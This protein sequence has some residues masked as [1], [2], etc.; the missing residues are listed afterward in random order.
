MSKVVDVGIPLLS[1]GHTSDEIEIQSNP[2]PKKN[3]CISIGG[4]IV[5]GSLILVVLAGAGLIA[6]KQPFYV[7]FLEDP[8]DPA[9]DITPEYIIRGGISIVSNV[10]CNGPIFFVFDFVES[11]RR[12][13]DSW[14]MIGGY[15][16]AELTPSLDT[17]KLKKNNLYIEV[18]RPLKY[19]VL[20]RKGN[21]KPGEIT[22]EEFK[23]KCLQDIPTRSYDIEPLKPFASQILE[24]TSKKGDT[25]AELP[26]WRKG[27]AYFSLIYLLANIPGCMI[28]NGELTAESPPN[29][30]IPR[31]EDYRELVVDIFFG[32][33][34]GNFALT[35]IAAPGHIVEWLCLR[36]LVQ[37]FASHLPK[38]VEYT[39]NLVTGISGPLLFAIGYQMY[40]PKLPKGFQDLSDYKLCP[41][42]PCLEMS[43]AWHVV[44]FSQS[45]VTPFFFWVVVNQYF[46]HL[47]DMYNQIIIY[48]QEKSGLA[49]STRCGGW[50]AFILFVGYAG[51]LGLV[52]SCPLPSWLAII[53]FFMI[54]TGSVAKMIRDY[55][56]KL[57]G[58]TPGMP[59]PALEDSDS[60]VVYPEGGIQ[61]PPQSSG[62]FSQLGG[63]CSSILNSFCCCK[64]NRRNY[65]LVGNPDNIV[66]S[67][68]T[69]A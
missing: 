48:H 62:F 34:V 7:P 32:I 30:L 56:Q 36:R 47:Y 25:F 8:F 31:R 39:S 54:N 28:A 15:E 45:L 49:I 18:G 20:D 65:S 37:K 58:L 16:L 29:L 63:W 60:H 19:L 10:I 66:G 4:M 24:I 67:N 6:I 26:R 64:S 44:Y 40:A 61:D 43:T 13:R 55:Y 38:W 14:K 27:L 50:S 41:D 52:K 69:F 33:G 68:I 59:I 5:K 1:N 12:L 21:Q 57:N 35:R 22:N 9:Q 23:E 11:C 46:A 53:G 42:E 2:Q 51:I 17:S 3:K